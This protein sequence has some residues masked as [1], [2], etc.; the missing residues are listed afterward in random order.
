MDS[1]RMDYTMEYIPTSER[2][3]YEIKIVFPDGT[4]VDFA[5]GHGKNPDLVD[6]IAKEFA[7]SHYEIEVAEGC[8]LV[9]YKVIY[10]LEDKP[11]TAAAVKRLLKGYP[12]DSNDLD[13]ISIKSHAQFKKAMPN[14]NLER[15][16]YFWKQYDEGFDRRVTNW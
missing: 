14:F 5:D 11:V 13:R 3:C 7:T 16:M 9:D 2:Y 15:Y 12:D 10:P 8:I 1:S 6:K 4:R